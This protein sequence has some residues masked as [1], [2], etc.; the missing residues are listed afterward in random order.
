MVTLWMQRLGLGFWY[1][2]QEW[3]LML[4]EEYPKGGHEIQMNSLD[5]D[6]WEGDHQSKVAM[7]RSCKENKQTE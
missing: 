1:E 3:K 2:P 5:I 4:K 7:F 6:R